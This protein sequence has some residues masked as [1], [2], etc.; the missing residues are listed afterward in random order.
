MKVTKSPMTEIN[1]NT[2]AIIDE[3]ARTKLTAEYE[4]IKVSV[5]ITSPTDGDANPIYQ[6]ILKVLRAFEDGTQLTLA[7][8]RDRAKEVVEGFDKNGMPTA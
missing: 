7:L 8:V 6:D 1:P 5:S 2:G 3:A 4:T